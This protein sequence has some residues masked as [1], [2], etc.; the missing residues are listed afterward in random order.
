MPHRNPD[1]SLS[2]CPRNT[3]TWGPRAWTLPL[4]SFRSSVPQSF[5]L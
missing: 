2:P 3:L 4:G 1:A 5:Q